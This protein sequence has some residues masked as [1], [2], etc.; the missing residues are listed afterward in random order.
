MNMKIPH[1][2]RT[3]PATLIWTLQGTANV[4]PS[5]FWSISKYFLDLV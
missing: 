1:G 5:Q 3:V 2:L 4:S